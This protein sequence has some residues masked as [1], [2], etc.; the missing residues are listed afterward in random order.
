MCALW[1]VLRQKL[2]CYRDGRGVS[3]WRAWAYQL[4]RRRD[5]LR[6]YSILPLEVTPAERVDKL[7]DDL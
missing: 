3:Q 7:V 5:I 4:A 2:D 6:G 1:C